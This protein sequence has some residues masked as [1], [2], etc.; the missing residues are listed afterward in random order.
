MLEATKKIE[1][2]AESEDM[3][4]QGLNRKAAR[5]NLIEQVLPFVGIVLLVVLFTILTKGRFIEAKNLDLLLKQCFTMVIV[6]IGAAFLYAM[7]TLDMAMGAVMS[8]SALLITKLYIAGVPLILSLLA[9]IIVSAVLMS[10][11]AFAK[12]YLKIDTFIASLCVMSISTGIVSLS[13]KVERT[14]FPYSMAPWLNEPV[15]KIIV[16]VVLLAAGFIGFKYTSFS[17]SLKAIGGN[18]MVA[19]ASGIRVKRIALLA[20]IVSGVL[21]GI[22]SLFEVVRGGVAD[23]SVGAGMNL[24]V[25]VGLVLGGFPLHGGSRARFSA[26]IIGAL[27]ITA[28][29]N[30]LALLGQANY[31]GYAIRGI[32]LIVVVSLAYDRSKGKLV[33]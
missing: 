19:Q 8:V 15:T 25:I 18:R 10:I 21:L 33:T 30:G 32:L 29:T 16:L 20:Y 12:N 2:A 17:R 4:Q 3:I 27:M 7:G 9:G 13:T 31:L 5:R 26:P 22:A 6:M 24:N 11:T 14:F 28:L 1:C 23:I